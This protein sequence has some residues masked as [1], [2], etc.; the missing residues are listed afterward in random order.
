MPTRL[1]VE[2]ILYHRAGPQL[3]LVWAA[4]R[5]S[6]Q[7]Y[8]PTGHT[9]LYDDP[10]GFGLALSGL[11]AANPVAPTDAEVGLVPPARFYIPFLDLATLRLLQS[12]VAGFLEI[13]ETVQDRSQS[14]SST[15][16]R[17]G[18]Q[19]K[20]LEE[21]YAGYLNP[22]VRAAQSGTMRFTPPTARR[23]G[24]GPGFGRLPYGPWGTY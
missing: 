4:G 10:I 15:G 12:T 22:N 19:L 3:D 14:W 1:D 21:R 5:A 8:L 24:W 6:D 2:T 7:P 18:D 16:T 11:R 23:P 13:D 17:W 9:P 20:S